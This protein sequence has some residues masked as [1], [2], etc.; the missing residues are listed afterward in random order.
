[1]TDLASSDPRV[2]ALRALIADWR[3]RSSGCHAMYS[4]PQATLFANCANELEAAPGASS[5]SPQEPWA[6]QIRRIADEIN[7]TMPTYA[8][9]GRQL[10]GLE[11]IADE[12]ERRIA[13]GVIAVSPD[14]A[15]PAPAPARICTCPFD[16]EGDCQIHHPAAPVLSRQVQE[17]KEDID[18]RADGQRLSEAARATAAT[19]MEISD[20]TSQKRDVN[21]CAICGWTLAGLA[22]QGCVRGNCS[23]RPF[24]S[25]FYDP[26]RA[27][28]EYAPHLDRDPRVLSDDDE[29]APIFSERPMFT[30]RQLDTIVKRAEAAAVEP[31]RDEINAAWFQIEHG[32]D[33][34]S[35]SYFEEEAPKNGF[36]FALAQA[37]AYLWKRGVKFDEPTQAAPAV[38]QPA[39]NPTLPCADESSSLSSTST[40][41][42]VGRE[43]GMF[44]MNATVYF[45]ENGSEY[46]GYF[47]IQGVQ[48][49]AWD[50]STPKVVR[51]D[52][53]RIEMDEHINRIAIHLRNE[54]MPLNEAWT[55]R[56]S[57]PPPHGD[58][59]DA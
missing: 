36:R 46:V 31:L 40:V 16:D 8:Q 59:R 7:R 21:R 53:V 55:E 50:P 10:L 30:P 18:S 56:A 14:P 42:S 12:I 2:P 37:I 15:A 32:Y 44:R 35:R 22:S 47:N 45:D 11:K 20:Q 3:L 33:I 54:Y 4:Y 49:I 1:M 13:Q 57:T 29:T 26:A 24:P 38:G 41:L 58:E 17:E 52:G 6:I 48:T 34:E 27:R 19:D 5:L 51:I 39:D 28:A 43:G 23:L 25:H 9:G